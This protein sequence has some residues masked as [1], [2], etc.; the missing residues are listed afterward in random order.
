MEHMDT[1]EKAFH[2][3][4]TLES[5]VVN[6]KIAMAIFEKLQNPLLKWAFIQG[7]LETHGR[8]DVD[9]VVVILSSTLS[10][11]LES[12]AEFADIPY[13]LKQDELFY[14]DINAVD[15]L[16]SVYHDRHQIFISSSYYKNYVR[17]LTGSITIGKCLVFKTCP[18]AILPHKTRTS[19]VGYDLSIIRKVKTLTANVSLYDTGIKIRVPHGYYTE[20]VPR[21]SLSKSGYLMANS[22]GI[23]DRSYNGNLYIAL[24]KIDESAP[25]IVFPFRC[26][27]LIVKKQ[28]HL[29][30]Q[31]TTQDLEATARGEGGFGSTG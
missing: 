1:P 11:L 26:C 12:I 29:Q 14:H 30:I 4:C 23:I 21:S 20:I 19:D 28:Y 17:I 24:A 2:T 22:I 27:Q 6:S 16:G 31:E 18:N 9:R 25:E 15:F 10:G 5:N 3:G 7:H 13:L 8:I